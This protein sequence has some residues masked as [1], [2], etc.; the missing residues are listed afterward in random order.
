MWLGNGAD[1]LTSKQCKNGRSQSAFAAERAACLPIEASPRRIIATACVTD[2]PR[3]FLVI[4]Y[5]L[6]AIRV[7]RALVVT[8]VDTGFLPV[9]RSELPRLK[10]AATCE[11]RASREV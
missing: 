6:A 8:D 2:S 9:L 1:R 4:P 3:A 10:M 11:Q 7:L 5:S